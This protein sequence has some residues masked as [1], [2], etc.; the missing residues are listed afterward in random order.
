MDSKSNTSHHISVNENN[1]SFICRVLN[2]SLL[3]NQKMTV[4][5]QYWDFIS[6]IILEHILTYSWAHFQLIWAPVV[7]VAAA[8][9]LTCSRVCYLLSGFIKTPE[10]L[11]QESFRQRSQRMVIAWVSSARLGCL[12]FMT[13]LN[14]LANWVIH[15][16]QRMWVII[17][18]ITAY[19]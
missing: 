12:N 5:S 6:T 4:L 13:P 19:D 15:D 3:A 2:S 14:F 10:V 11:Q 9:Q 1:F 18:R 8:Q 16:I 17:S 7:V